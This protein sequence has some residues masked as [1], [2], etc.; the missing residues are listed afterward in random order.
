MEEL[1]NKNPVS[2]RQD[3]SDIGV[4]DSSRLKFSANYATLNLKLESNAHSRASD[5]ENI[6]F[7]DPTN[8]EEMKSSFTLVADS[9]WKFIS[10]DNSQDNEFMD[11]S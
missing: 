6:Q 9:V 2:D 10:V 4:M 11:A 1:V 3:R 7:W 5:G 8:L